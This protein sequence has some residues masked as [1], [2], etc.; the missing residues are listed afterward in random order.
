MSIIENYW[1]N[2]GAAAINPNKSDKAKDTAV[3][4]TSE[5][6][7]I[8]EIPDSPVGRDLVKP[9]EKNNT[10][11]DSQSYNNIIKGIAELV[12]CQRSCDVKAV[13]KMVDEHPE[14]IE[15]LRA[16]KDAEGEDLLTPNDIIGIIINCKNDLINHQDKVQA[17]FS[18]PKQIEMLQ[19]T[20]QGKRCVEFYRAMVDPLQS[21]VEINPE[22]F[23][24]ADKVKGDTPYTD[25]LSKPSFPEKFDKA[26]F[27]KW[28]KD[29]GLSM[30]ADDFGYKMFDAD[31][32]VV[33]STWL[34]SKSG[35][36]IFDKIVEYDESRQEKVAYMKDKSEQELKDKIRAIV[37]AKDGST[38]NIANIHSD[39]KWYGLDGT[40]LETN[41][42]TSEKQ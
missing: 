33:R 19:K 15:M 25:F 3:S 1:S 37:Y 18:D 28:A 41:P 9:A 23:K 8:T 7:Q 22:A 2:I 40:L 20:P 11:L 35:D 29:S 17:A 34:D 10:S 42:I 12:V 38:S 6:P 4:E 39:G 14:V 13:K 30:E 16:P 21:T 27:E 26:E 31:G 5:R 36:I 24:K 32:N